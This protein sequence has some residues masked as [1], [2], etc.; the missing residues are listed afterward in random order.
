MKKTCL[1][2]AQ[3]Q[4]PQIT[5]KSSLNKVEIW[6]MLLFPKIVEQLEFPDFGCQ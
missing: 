4:L 6:K 1:Q 3:D 2:I 5:T